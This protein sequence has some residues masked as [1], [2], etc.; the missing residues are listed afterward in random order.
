MYVRIGAIIMH[1]CIG[2]G[3]ISSGLMGK[4]TLI[5]RFISNTTLDFK[6]MLYIIDATLRPTRPKLE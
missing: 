2:A 6:T 1:A 4:G 5:L 3:L